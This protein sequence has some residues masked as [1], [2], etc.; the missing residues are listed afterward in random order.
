MKHHVFL[1]AMAVLAVF[2]AFSQQHSLP[3]HDR[4]SLSLSIG[5]A[6]PV[7]EFANKNGNDAASGLAN[8]G[9][10]ADLTYMHPFSRQDFGY[11]GTLRARMNGLSSSSLRQPF[12][13]QYPGYNWYVSAKSWETAAALI[14]LYHRSSEPNNRFFLDES[15]LLGAAEAV[16]PAETITGINGSTSNPPD[17]DLVQA[18]NNKKY[19]TTITFMLRFGGGVK[20]SDKLSLIA[21]VDYWW[22]DP[23]FR[24]LTQTVT[25][26][27]GFN[28]PINYYNLSLASAASLTRSEFTS[29]YTQNMSSIDLSFGL[30]LRL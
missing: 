26:A 9:G 17:P 7:G 16:L 14:G 12:A 11:T 2:N 30:S 15:L 13:D 3:P 6:F 21:H 24:N 22:L 5:P 29:D 25:T 8:I 27:T 18:T 10:L 23:V 19:A 1:T 4:G 20:L 28:G